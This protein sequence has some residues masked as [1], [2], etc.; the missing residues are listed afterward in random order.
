VPASGALI[1]RRAASGL[2]QSDGDARLRT[3][4]QSG[5]ESFLNA[6]HPEDRD[7]LRK[8]IEQGFRSQVETRAEF[9]SV[10]PAARSG[11]FLRAGARARLQTECR[12]LNGRHC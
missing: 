11:G 6:V 9:R 2:L 12:K 3:R 10:L 5:S 8:T 4:I 1:Q 7:R